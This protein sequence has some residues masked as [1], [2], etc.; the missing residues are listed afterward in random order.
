[1]SKGPINFVLYCKKNQSDEGWFEV[2]TGKNNYEDFGRIV[3]Y[4]HMNSMN[5]W[6]GDSCNQL[7]GTDGI[8]FPPY[9]FNKSR[10][11]VLVPGYYIQV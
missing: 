7:N 9:L 8:I 6:N 3:S 1:M 5:I 10:L 2:R 11:Y 4:N